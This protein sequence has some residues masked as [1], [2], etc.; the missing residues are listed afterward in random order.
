[1]RI[2]HLSFLA[3]SLSTFVIA[4]GCG[5]GMAPAAKQPAAAGS[6]G[7]EKKEQSLGVEAAQRREI[8]PLARQK[9]AQDVISGEVEASA[10]PQIE[11]TSGSIKIVIPIGTQAPVECFVYH[12]RTDGAGTI[13]AIVAEIGKKLDVRLFEPTDVSAVAGH[14]VLA[15]HALYVVKRPEGDAA[16]DLKLA[17]FEHPLV[18]TLCTH[19]E[20]GYASSFQRVAKSLFESVKRSDKKL[21]AEPTRWEVSAIKV[22][23]RAIGY[24][25]T[26]DYDSGKGSVV[27]E[28]IVAK[29]IPRSPRE[30]LAEDSVTTET[31]D[32]TGQLLNYVH[33]SASGAEVQLQMN[34]K[35]LA[36]GEY[37]YSGK[38]DGKPVSGKF[39][40]KS[41]AGP[42]TSKAISKAIREQLLAGKSRS[43]KLEEY[44][45]S[46]DP[47]AP[48]E[49][50]YEVESKEERRVRSS[51]GPV[52]MLGTVD[53]HGDLEKAEVHV[54]PVV[55]TE[56]RISES[57]R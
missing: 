9:F 27:S 40:T 43:V 2:P 47:T 52:K 5:S 36:A 18:T 35:R 55:I 37:A 10:S 4:T 14:A 54:G 49:A 24:S 21:E 44:V 25:A 42:A 11:R 13:S 57:K 39:K 53:A 45:P 46:L 41:K 22:N 3:V 12:E 32:R 29:L 33:V 31:S 56:E 20:M 38:Q 8:E 6:S 19:D 16:G 1:V 50:L 17:F 23:G 30:S 26:A 7:S 28:S 48:I 51:L 15:A 34:L